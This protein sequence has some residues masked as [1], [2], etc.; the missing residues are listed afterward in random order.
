M[1]TNIKKKVL[2]VEDDNALKSVLGDKLKS[3]DFLVLT[4]KDG[5]EGLRVALKNKPD[6]I[7]LDVVMPKMNGLKMLEKLREDEWGEHVPVL[8]LSNDDDPE[9][10]KETLKY[11][12]SDYLIKSDWELED[13]IKKIKET[14]RL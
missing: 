1:D 5:E 12:A 7:L 10:I 6:L 2:I 13:I 14:L 4:A 11:N 3:E 8:L 9:H